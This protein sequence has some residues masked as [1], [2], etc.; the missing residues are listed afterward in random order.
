MLAVTST[1]EGGG[2]AIFEPQGFFKVL[3]CF[4]GFRSFS[5]YLGV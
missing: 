5:V 3:A 1:V 4:H 2:G